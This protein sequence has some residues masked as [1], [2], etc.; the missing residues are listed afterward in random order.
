M[1]RILLALLLVSACAVPQ[2]EDYM[3]GPDSQPQDGVPKGT[4]TKFTLAPGKD[5]PGTPHNCAVYVPAQYDPGKPTPFMIFLD[6]SQALGDSMRVPVVLDNLIAKHDLPPMIAIFVDPGILPVVSDPSH[7]DIAQNRYNRIYEYDSLTPRF[8]DFLVNELIPEVAKHYN[9]SK[10]PDDRALSGVSTGAVGAFMAAWNRP[11]QFHRVLSLIGTYVS[12]KG[13]DALPALVR[14]TEP[15]PIRIFM[16]DGTADHIVLA[17]P[18][19]T[20]FAGS[21]P[22]NNQVMYEALEF[23]GYDAKLVMGTEGHNLKHGGAILPDA[24]RWLWR[25][26]PAPIVV[27]EPAAAQKPG[28]DPSA[29]VFSTIF[30]DMPWQQV[31]GDYGS[32]SSL[33]SDR[34]GNV[35][36]ADSNAGNIERVDANGKITQ[37]AEPPNDTSIL[38]VGAND[39]LYTYSPSTGDIVSSNVA[40]GTASDQKTIARNMAAVVDF[41]VTETSTIY[42]LDGSAATI[43]VIDSSGQSRV[44]LHWTELGGEMAAP[45][46]LALSPDQSMLVVTDTVSRYSWS[47]QIAADGTL[48]NGE[49]FYRLELPET[50]VMSWQSGTRGAVED[51]NGMVYFV[52][53]LGIQIAMQN[54]RVAEILNPPVPGAP[55]TAITFA[56]TGDASWLYVAENGKLYR[57]PVKVTGANAW[58]V[59]KPPKPTL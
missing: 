37:F 38:R 39:R 32:I 51:V 52:T 16:Q 30:V 11:D 36:F 25:D 4:V 3:L 48:E 17:E 13:A 23:A 31:G 29:T 42:F 45:R 34:E 20:S 9:L 53:P 19:G 27:H 56:G 40:T 6:G 58:T 10:N 8:S 50:T 49:P 26:Y 57:R 12:M 35:Y 18:Y 54:G 21:W 22:I 41:V 55:I 5:Y 1:R 14:K 43:G 15:K 2:A 44:A 33:T 7:A 28:W 47:F 46:G 24:L 59:V